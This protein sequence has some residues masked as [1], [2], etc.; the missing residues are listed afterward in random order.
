MSWS[1]A[2]PSTAPTNS[3]RSM[4]IS[5]AAPSRSPTFMRSRSASRRATATTATCSRARSCRR[6]SSRPA[7]RRCASRSWRATSTPSCGRPC[8]RATAISSPII[9]TGSS[10]TARPMCARSSATSCSRATKQGA[11]TL[12]IEVEEK[13]IDALARYDNRGTKARGPLEYLGSTTLNNMLHMH[14][15]FTFTY[16]G[17]SQARELHYLAGNYRQVLTPEGLSAFVN[18]SVSYGHPGIP[19]LQLFDYKTRSTYFESGLTYPLV[20]QREK[21]LAFSLLWFMSHDES[22]ILSTLNTLDRLRGV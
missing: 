16:A 19:E 8:S 13:P 22:D 1:R 12:V 3:P 2:R 20:R 10:P 21:N 11:A 15:A 14:D 18:A 7:A 4:P 9:P 6:N 17:T 5:S